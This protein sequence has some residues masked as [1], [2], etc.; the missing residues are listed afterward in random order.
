MKILVSAYAC[1]PYQGSEPS[2]G[3]GFIYELS[4]QHEITA[5]VE[6][7][8]FR[9]DIEHYLENNNDHAKT[10][11]FIF[12]K[13]NRNR[14]LRRIWPPSYYWYYR[15]WHK[16]VFQIAKNMLSNQ[17]FDLVHQLNMSG[18]REP[19]FLWKLD[20]PFV[21]GPVGG[22]G[23]FPYKFFH[24]VGIKGSLYYLAYN[25]FNF[26]HMNFLC[27]PRLAAKKAGVGLISATSDNKRSIKNYWSYRS[28]LISEIGKPYIKNSFSVG[29]RKIGDPLHLVWSGQHTPG[30]ALNIA[31]KALS[32]ISKDIKW[33]FHILGNGELTNKWKNYAHSLGIAKNCK[34]YGLV[35]RQEALKIMEQSNLMLITSLRDLT[36]AVTVESVSLGLPVI[37]LD[38]SGFSDVIDESCGIKIPVTNFPD[39]TIEISKAI[40][41]LALDNNLLAELAEGAFNKSAMYSWKY[42]V[43]ILHQVYR[44]KIDEYNSEYD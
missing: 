13:K 28:T 4:K 23:Y 17:K 1:S 30:K 19:G 37:C 34:F 43:D 11:K 44:K 38:H 5:F 14:R 15:A 24:H 40:E 42:K 7:E 22:M 8:K 39:V 33:K 27:R 20:L 18:F 10:I 21:W 26:L 36:S 25:V 12:V 6:E 9:K 35:T 32:L 2:S 29:R 41:T 31:L 3:W 16:K